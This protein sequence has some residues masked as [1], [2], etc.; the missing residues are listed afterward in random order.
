MDTDYRY[1][2]EIDPT[3][4]WTKETPPVPVPGVSRFR[5]W[6][7]PGL[8]A[9]V[10][11]IIIIVLGATNV[12]TSSRLGSAEQRVSHL[13]DAIQTL[14]ASLQHVHETA[15]DVQRLQFAVQNNKDQLISALDAL[16]SLDKVESLSQSVAAITCSLQHIINNS[17]SPGHC[18]PLQWTLFGSD[19]YFFSVDSLSWNESRIWCEQQNSHLVILHTDKE[20]DFVTRRSVPN[21][22]WVG[23][24]DWR[25]GKWEWVNQTP[26]TLERRRWAPGQPDNW[27]VYGHGTEDC[28]HLH[29]N[30]HLNDMFCTMKVRFICQKHSV[31]T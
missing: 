11:L 13:I 17:S 31:H 24:S 23:L 20:W 26:Y 29:D 3:H 15:E 2:N 25:T 8:M 14:N 6:L 9:A 5:R 18:C 19:C 27:S 4:L 10:L 16:K 22:Y 7:F 30:G 28:A 21:F 12:R 1:E